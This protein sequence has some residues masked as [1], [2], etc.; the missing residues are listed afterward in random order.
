M[1]VRFARYLYVPEFIQHVPSTA[2]RALEDA[3]VENQLAAKASG[4]NADEWKPFRP[5]GELLAYAEELSLAL[6]TL[7]IEWHPEPDAISD[8]FLPSNKSYSRCPSCHKLVPTDGATVPHPMTGELMT[9]P[10][11]HCIGCGTPFEKWET[12]NDRTVFR[13]VF[14]IALLGD[15][16]AGTLPTLAERVPQFVDV[17]REVLDTDVRE[18]FVAW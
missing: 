12:T 4:L 8:P 14:H 6:P 9:I 13:S 2:I 5:Q 3:L 18:V 7:A 16:F 10:I 15:S 1:L 11:D 17:V